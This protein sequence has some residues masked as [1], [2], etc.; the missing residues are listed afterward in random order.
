[1]PDIVRLGRTLSDQGFL[2]R[3]LNLGAHWRDAGHCPAGPDKIQLEVSALEV[4]KKTWLDYFYFIHTSV[5]IVR[6]FYTQGI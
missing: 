3:I 2:G 5:L 1:M 4:L 6:C